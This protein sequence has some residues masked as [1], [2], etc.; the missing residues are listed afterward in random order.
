MILEI[1]T[2]LGDEIPAY[3]DDGDCSKCQFNPWKIHEAFL[4]AFCLLRPTIV[5]KNA[6][7]LCYDIEPCFRI[8]LKHL[9]DPGT[10]VDLVQI[11]HFL[12]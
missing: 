12:R 9:N 6:R 5:W 4:K 7:D 11:S 2:H 1:M 8:A 3:D 10:R